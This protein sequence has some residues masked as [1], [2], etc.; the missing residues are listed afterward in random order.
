[1]GKVV[2][3]PGYRYVGTVKKLWDGVDEIW[4]PG[5]DDPR[6]PVI[7]PVFEL[8]EGH[9]FLEWVPL[10][11]KDPSKGTSHVS[12]RYTRLEVDPETGEREPQRVEASC[13]TCGARYRNECRQGMPRQHILRFAQARLH[14]APPQARP[15]VP[16]ARR[17]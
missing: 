6:T 2:F 5:K 17:P 12:A 9:S 4:P 7:E 16:G 8:E 3:F 1:M 13:A 15:T 14:R 11:A 10:F